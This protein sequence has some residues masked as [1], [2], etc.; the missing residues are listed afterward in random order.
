MLFYE[1]QTIYV[2]FYMTLHSNLFTVEILMFFG[3]KVFESR[4]MCQIWC[5]AKGSC[6]HYN[7]WNTPMA[8]SVFS[9]IVLVDS[10]WMPHEIHE[11]RDYLRKIFLFILFYRF[12]SS[13][14]IPFLFF[15]RS[16]L[17]IKLVF[18]CL[19]IDSRFL[20]EISCFASLAINNTDFAFV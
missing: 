1:S 6:C 5:Y 14:L 2:W 9:L 8:H 17:I 18:S 11:H 12:F 19:S 3:L 10:L 13:S 7:C 20:A 4:V 15:I 16:S